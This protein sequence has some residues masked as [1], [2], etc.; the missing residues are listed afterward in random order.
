MLKIDL[1]KAYISI[2]WEFL[3]QALY[4]L[5]FHPC[6]IHWV[7]KGRLKMVDRLKHLSVSQ[8]CSICNTHSETHDHLFFLCKATK[9]VWLKVRGWLR[10][11]R[12]MTT[13]ASA[14]KHMKREKK[15]ARLL[16]KRRSISPWQPRSD[17]YGMRVTV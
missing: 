12:R 3:T 2:S 5:N 13:I 14:I 4:G 9:A 8:V 10:I 17:T 7:M 11:R 15:G 6:F 16:N 1:Q